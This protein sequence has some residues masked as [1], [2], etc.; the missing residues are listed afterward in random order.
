MPDPGI[1]Y[2]LRLPPM[3]VRENLD[4]ARYA[5]RLGVDSSWVIETR[6][7]ADAVTPL[8]AYSAVTE[9]M[10]MGTAVIP[11]W[12][13]NPALIAQT[14]ATLDANA[15]GRIILGLGAWWEPLAT[16]VGVKRERAIRAMREVVESV[17]LLLKRDAPVTYLG[18][19]VHLEDVF[20]DHDGEGGHD[21]K[22]FVA[23]V[24]PQMLRLAGRIADG[25]ILNS[26]HTVGATRRAVDEIRKG[27]E[28][29]GRSMDA[30]E[31][32]KPLPLRVNRDRQAALDFDKPR[33]AQYIA[34]QPHV[35]GP[36]EVDPELASKLK[37]VIPFPATRAQVMEGARL[38]SNELVESL[39]CYG[40]VEEVV[41]R[42]GEFRDAGV[43]LPITEADRALVDALA[44][45]S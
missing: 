4:L 8:G 15:P 21:V 12:T 16:N 32:V 2:G 29:A 9:R 33:I 37:D 10:K 42:A 31:R 13:R 28:A 1:R 39:G 3:G 38:I 23:A 25:V 44:G 20:L 22:I 11:L 17:R 5:D 6:L 43:T 40:D 19:Y 14:F 36:T 41:S 26:N 30:I 35:E 18:E 45:V 24:G 7:T 27:A 34:Q